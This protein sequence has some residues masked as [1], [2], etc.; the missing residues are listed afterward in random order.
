MFE[1]REKECTCDVLSVFCGGAGILV[2]GVTAVDSRCVHEFERFGF[3]LWGESEY[4]TDG[5]PSEAR[6]V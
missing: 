5:I 4:T 1:T 6:L 3:E 2:A